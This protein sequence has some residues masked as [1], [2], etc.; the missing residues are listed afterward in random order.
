MTPGEGLMLMDVM[1]EVVDDP[2]EFCVTE[3]TASRT[4]TEGDAIAAR[5]ARWDDGWEFAV[6]YKIPSHDV[7]DLVALVEEEIGESPEPLSARQI[8]KAIRDYWLWLFTREIQ[9]PNLVS[10]EG[11][12]IEL[13]TDHWKV[14]DEPELVRRLEAEAD[15]DGDREHGWARLEDPDADMG[16]VLLGLRFGRPDR[17]EV[18]AQTRQRADEGRLWL[19]RVAGSSLE[20]LTREIVDPLSDKMLG[21]GTSGGSG[22]GLGSSRDGLP[23]ESGEQPAPEDVRELI[24]QVYRAQ[25]GGLADEP[26][27]MLGDVTPREKLKQ[28]GG[29]R[30]VRLWLDGFEA[31]ERRMAKEQGRELIDLG[32][33]WD[34]V[35]LER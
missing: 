29:E 24:E 5:L 18:F 3:R 32:F 4:L 20:F 15:V 23:P 28:P 2:E 13:T 26:I 7:L 10:S 21:G 9:L 35:G 8:G 25:Y 27:P 12:R 22:E 16:R 31:N 6:V 14:L 17:L 1:E 11:G 33:L 19:E 34:A 30:A